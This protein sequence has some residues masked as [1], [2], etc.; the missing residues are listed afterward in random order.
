MYL[1]IFV[2]TYKLKIK[3]NYGECEPDEILET[4]IFVTIAQNK[5]GI[6]CHYMKHFKA[7]NGYDNRNSI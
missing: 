2:I 3:L 4:I 6:N 5:T 7:G 1:L